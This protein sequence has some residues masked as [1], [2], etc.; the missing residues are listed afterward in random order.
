MKKLEK[1]PRNFV[2]KKREIFRKNSKV[3]RTLA[4][5]IWKSRVYTS[6]KKSYSQEQKSSLRKTFW[7]GLKSWSFQNFSGIYKN[8]QEISE[9][10]YFFED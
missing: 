2:K 10:L 3:L 5:N 9:S 7:K 8:S 1:G 6:S 4:K